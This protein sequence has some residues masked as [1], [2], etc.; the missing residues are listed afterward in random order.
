MGLLALL[1]LAIA[2][3]FEPGVRVYDEGFSLTN[4]WRLTQGERPYRDYWTAYPPGTAL[5]LAAAFEVAGATVGV[6]RSVNAAWY[7]AFVLS[8]FWMLRGFVDRWAAL[9]ATAVLDVLLVAAFYPSYSVVPAVTAIV[10]ALALLSKGLATRRLPWFAGSG[11]VGG[12]TLAFRHDFSL[13]F[14]VALTASIAWLGGCRAVGRGNSHSA[15]RAGLAVAWV[16]AIGVACLLLLAIV[17]CCGLD[18]FID[19]SLIFPATGMR[20]HRVLDAPS[21]LGILDRVSID[22]FLAWLVPIGLLALAPWVVVSNRLSERNTVMIVMLGMLSG[23]LTSQTFGR[24]DIVHAAPSLL[25]FGLF[26]VVLSHALRGAK[27]QGPLRWVTCALGSLLLAVVALAAARSI[28]VGRHVRCLSNPGDSVC[29]AIAD[30]ERAAAAYVRDLT[31]SSD[32][33]FVGNTR[34]DRISVNDAFLYFLIQ[35]P[36]P[37]KWNEMHPG[38]VTTREVQ[39]EIV[40]SL[41]HHGVRI[42]VLA[43]MPL[44]EEPNLSARSSPVTRLD[45]YLASQFRQLHVIGRYRILVRSRC[46]G[47]GPGH[48]SRQ[49]RT[50]GRR[51]FA[52]R[53][54][55]RLGGQRDRRDDRERAGLGRRNAQAKT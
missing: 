19:Q 46:S 55:R 41:E 39:E 53:R 25:L 33:V 15:T 49:L 26:V 28:D 24:F 1:A 37:M 11:V 21:V 48:A 42:V 36:I 32:C 7:C 50:G 43:D 20:A 13:Y 38:V 16:T 30:D 47:L 22:W 29:M 45:D 14:V 54:G 17:V 35:R 34:H 4:A 31:T 18:D 27:F 9:A 51:R 8:A 40:E 10:L 6:A 3:S 12:L 52:G 2:A 5:V 23:L 44:F